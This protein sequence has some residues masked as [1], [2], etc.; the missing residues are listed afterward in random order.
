MAFEELKA[1]AERDVGQRP[2]RPDRRVDR[3]LARVG[4]GRARS[5]PGRALLDL[6]L[7]HRRGRGADRRR[8]VRLSSAST[9][10]PALIE[11]AKRAGGRARARHRLSRRRLRAARGS[12]CVATTPSVL[13]SGSCSPPTTQAAA[14]E[15][16]RITKP[17]GRI[18]LA[19]WTPGAA[20]CAGS[21]QGHAPVPARSAALEPVRLGR[22]GEGRR[23]PRRRIRP[24]VRHE[25]EHRHLRLGRGVL[26]GLLAELRPDQVALRVSRRSRRGD[27]PGVAGRVRRRNARIR[28]SVPTSS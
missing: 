16:A 6:A 9:S 14:S 1:A 7:W 25:D 11:T 24:D 13:A 19:N 5:T 17:G 10:R 20:R 21:L 4:R 27:A 23:A 22:R 2:V 3:G 18:A 15:L 28:R 8:P 26:A 12:R